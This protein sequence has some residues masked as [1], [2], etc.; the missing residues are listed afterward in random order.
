MPARTVCGGLS[1]SLV[2]P[3]RWSSVLQRPAI[4]GQRAHQRAVLWDVVGKIDI[5]RARDCISARTVTAIK[6]LTL[7]SQCPW[8]SVQVSEWLAPLLSVDLC[9]IACAALVADVDWV[10]GA[11]KKQ[12][13]T[14]RRSRSVWFSRII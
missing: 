3:G 14:T 7:Q 4:V 9:I 13:H 1:G 11:W 6:T 8:L 10:E 5:K 12:L 2:L